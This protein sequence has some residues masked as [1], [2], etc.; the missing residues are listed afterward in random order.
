MILVPF[1]V[2]SKSFPING[3]FNAVLRLQGFMDLRHMASFPFMSHAI[4]H[5]RS[6]PEEFATIEELSSDL[7]FENIREAA[8]VRIRCALHREEIPI[9]F[10]SPEECREEILSYVLC[11]ILI[12]AAGDTHLIRWY[13][14]AEAV[15]ARRLLEEAPLFWVMEM[16]AD[17][18]FSIQPHDAEHVQIG[19]VEF[20]RYSSSLKS[21]DW[22]LANQPLHKGMILLKKSK[23]IRLIQEALKQKFEEEVFQ[24]KVPDTMKQLFPSQMGEITGITSKMK[25][26]YD[27]QLAKVVI[28]RRF[29]PCIH[30]LIS[31]TRS[32]ENVS[33]S[34]RFAMTAFLLHIGMTVDEI[35][36][37]FRVSPDFRED[38]ARYQVEHISGE[39]SG[40]DYDSMAC[41]TMV[42]YGLCVGKDRLCVKI[43]HP[44]SYYEARNDDALPGAERRVRRALSAS[45]EIARVLKVPIRTIKDK[46][47]TWF[48][49]VAV[50]EAPVILEGLIPALQKGPATGKEGDEVI[51]TGSQGNG[52]G[53]TG[54]SL[55]APSDAGNGKPISGSISDV[56]GGGKL[57]SSDAGTGNQISDSISDVPGEGK[58]T[59]SDAGTDHPR[60]GKLGSVRGTSKPYTRFDDCRSDERAVFSVSVARAWLNG[61]KVI[62]PGTMETTY[63]IGTT[64]LVE[65]ARGR[66][67][68]LLPVLDFEH[69][70]MIRDFQKTGKI[71]EFEGQILSV[72][73]RPFMH[74]IN[75]QVK[76]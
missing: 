35:V 44:L 49:E 33:H 37:L 72:N 54:E 14:L 52:L 3:T 1:S 63:L 30:N 67:I 38:L 42:T 22:K 25:E 50:I 73:G 65:D 69:G 11:R 40:T 19:F 29:P 71:L 7:L 43:S 26:S 20:I 68:R 75:V 18:G 28:P 6:H 59:V 4:A 61:M 24:M 32:G 53:H 51:D 57:A 64:G 8:M 2:L 27:N 36:D 12:A 34:G 17:I 62:H 31:M 55:S 41:K 48:N 39:V 58:L 21:F 5:F 9:D 13:S 60:S 23:L 76:I 45:T 47:N 10:H 56:P 66:T 74:V 16:A 46:V 15:R 70:Q